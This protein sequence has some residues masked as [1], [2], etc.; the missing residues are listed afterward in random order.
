MTSI[1][2][3]SEMS[4]LDV[5]WRSDL[6]WPGSKI[7]SVRK[8]CM[9]RCANNLRE[10]FN[11]P[12][13]PPPGRRVLMHRY[14]A[15][16]CLSSPYDYPVDSWQIRERFP[17]IVGTN[18]R[19]RSSQPRLEWDR[20]FHTFL[21][22][23]RTFVVGQSVRGSSANSKRPERYVCYNA[24][25]CSWQTNDHLNTVYFLGNLKTKI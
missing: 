7:F 18:W 21:L 5:T 22:H 24:V 16:I 3:F 25:P 10:M 2:F 8:R 23:L 14:E 17:F 12:P 11:L 6:E 1:Q 20:K 9:N 19:C 13:P 15:M 4:S